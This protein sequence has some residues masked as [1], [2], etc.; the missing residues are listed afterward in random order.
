VAL[1]HRAEP[2][3]AMPPEM[4]GDTITVTAPIA[5]VLQ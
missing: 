4:Q 1:I 3:P 5:F 2:L